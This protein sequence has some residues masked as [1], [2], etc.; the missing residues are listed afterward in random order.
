MNP[1]F[2]ELRAWSENFPKST[3]HQDVHL[4]F[5]PES[6]EAGA[7]NQGFGPC[8]VCDIG[9]RLSHHDFRP[10]S[11]RKPGNLAWFEPLRDQEMS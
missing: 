4:F 1:K 5:D 7:R 2:H 8:L 9:V 3:K 11:T 6:V 10:D